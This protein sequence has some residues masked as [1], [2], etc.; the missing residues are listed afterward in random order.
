MSI[1]GLIRFDSGRASILLADL[2]ILSKSSQTTLTP[3][4]TANMVCFGLF[5]PDFAA[6]VKLRK[7]M[8]LV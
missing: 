3:R 8:N 5:P 1:F 4:R 6:A 2:D 7:K